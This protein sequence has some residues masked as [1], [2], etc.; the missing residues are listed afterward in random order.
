MRSNDDYDILIN[1]SVQLFLALIVV[2]SCIFSGTGQA[3]CRPGPF[4]LEL[5]QYS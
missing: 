2:E 5:A 4:C 3:G 1:S